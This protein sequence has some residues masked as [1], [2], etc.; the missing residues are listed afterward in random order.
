MT[1]SDANLPA[2]ATALLA[3]YPQNHRGVL[4]LHLH[5]QALSPTT[6]LGQVAWQYYC[7]RFVQGARHPEGWR[8][9]W[10]WVYQRAAATPRHCLRE[11]LTGVYLADFDYFQD[12]L[13]DVLLDGAEV[14][15]A[16][17]A[18]AQQLLAAAFDAPEVTDLRI[19][20]LGDGEVIIGLLLAAQRSNGEVIML[21][22]L[23]D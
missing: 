23:G 8:Q 10:Q 4:G 7:D 9:Q 5:Y 20:R 15:S 6:D 3:H 2:Y 13:L 17:A 14:D 1:V 11:L 22:Y 18:P 21:A 16:E 12:P 19:Y